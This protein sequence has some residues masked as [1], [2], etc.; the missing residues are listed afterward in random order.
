MWGEGRR[1]REDPARWGSGR[2]RERVQAVPPSQGPSRGHAA[3]RLR[4]RTAPVGWPAGRLLHPS[5]RASG[6]RVVRCARRRRKES[7]RL[8][9]R[10]GRNAR[11]FRGRQSRKFAEAGSPM[12]QPQP[13][14]GSPCHRRAFDGA[15]S[16]EAVP[17]RWHDDD[18][19]RLLTL[20]SPTR[21]TDVCPSGH[22]TTSAVDAG[23]GP[24]AA[25][26]RPLPACRTCRSASCEQR[27]NL[28]SSTVKGVTM[29]RLRAAIHTAD[30]AADVMCPSASGSTKT[31]GS[32]PQSSTRPRL[33]VKGSGLTACGGRTAQRACAGL[34]L[35]SSTAEALNCQ[36]VSA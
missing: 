26:T 24:S 34:N 7:T 4:R 21:W 17:Q 22:R 30:G 1:P 28:Q 10:A 3:R 13:Q 14:D 11:S 29:R 33:G 15:R 25:F 18:R 5:S 9:A 2:G 8:A 36:R 32:S 23:H 20:A 16:G 35:R 27:G 12:A 6:G 19:R 31:T